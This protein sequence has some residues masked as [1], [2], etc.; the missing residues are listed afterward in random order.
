MP[1]VILSLRVPVSE[2]G[3]AAYRDAWPG[4][5]HESSA[6]TLLREAIA[7]WD[8]EGLLGFPASDPEVLHCEVDPEEV[9]L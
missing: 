6:E 8:S 3:L 2:D 9:L 4:T 7:V 5:L 1:D